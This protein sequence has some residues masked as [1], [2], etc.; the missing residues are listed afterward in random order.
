[1]SGAVYEALYTHQKTKKVKKWQEGKVK[2][3]GKKVEM[4]QILNNLLFVFRSFCK[5]RKARR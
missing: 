2:I 4:N 5:V 1:M 3:V